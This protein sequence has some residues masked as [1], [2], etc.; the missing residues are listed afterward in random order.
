[1]QLSRSL[2]A[3]ALVGSLVVAPAKADFGLTDHGK[4]FVAAT[5]L[6]LGATYLY[7]RTATNNP[8]SNPLVKAADA[9][10]NSLHATTAFLGKWKAAAGVGVL[11]FWAAYH[12]T[13]LPNTYAVHL[14][15]DLLFKAH[16]HVAP[17]V[18]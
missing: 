4:K 16:H 2:L 5:A 12:N 17:V 8:S 9:A 10:T 1:M 6:A 15:K 18:S 14:A 13:N 7:K 3:M 11:T